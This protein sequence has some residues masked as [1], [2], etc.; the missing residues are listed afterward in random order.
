M[1]ALAIGL[2]LLAGL[3]A[4]IYPAWRAS[5][6]FTGNADQHHLRGGPHGIGPIF[7]GLIRKKIAVTLLVIEIAVTM[8]VVLNCINLVID[9]RKRLTIPSGVD[10]ENIIV[11]SIQKLRPG[12]SGRRVR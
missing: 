1:I 3:G 4:G 7:R 5:R 11:L 8:A 6:N 2:A 9:N 10:E 12:V